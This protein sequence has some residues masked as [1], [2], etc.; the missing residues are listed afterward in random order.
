MKCENLQI[1]FSGNELNDLCDVILTQ[2][3]QAKT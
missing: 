2:M 3:F 1:K